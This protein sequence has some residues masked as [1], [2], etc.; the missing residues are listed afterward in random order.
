MGGAAGWPVGGWTRPGSGIIGSPDLRGKR[1]GSA[2]PAHSPAAFPGS[3]PRSFSTLAGA[4]A[5]SS[6]CG[7]AAARS[8]RWRTGPGAPR[9]RS[10]GPAGPHPPPAQPG[11]GAADWPHHWPAR[12][13]VQLPSI[14]HPAGRCGPS[15][16]LS[17]GFFLAPPGRARHTCELP[18]P[19][20]QRAARRRSQ[21]CPGRPGRLRGAVPGARAEDTG[22]AGTCTD[23]GRG[24]PSRS[25][26]S[27]QVPNP[28][29]RSAN[30]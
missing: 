17:L 10:R 4:L 12:K 2:A 8:R 21:L 27:S 28:R 19:D 26:L 30:L 6:R 24:R 7:S 23:T 29:V 9:P 1:S 11:L 14:S 3:R 20:A 13:A 5:G 18:G 16:A 15:G 25:Q 22:P